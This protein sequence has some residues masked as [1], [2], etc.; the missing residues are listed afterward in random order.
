MSDYLDDFIAFLTIEQ[1]ASAHT[2]EAYRRDI[3][4]FTDWLS[5]DTEKSLETVSHRDLARYISFLRS[6]EQALSA[7]S[8]ERRLSAISSY[9]KYLA[10]E[11]V[12][13]NSSVSQLARRKKDQR[14]PKYLSIVQ[15]Q[16]LLE[17][18]DPEQAANQA[19]ALRD[20]AMIELLYSSGLR[21]GELCSLRIDQVNSDEHFIRVMGKGSKE[22]IVPLGS[23]AQA[24]LE[25][26]LLK[27]RNELKPR[28]G[29]AA[30]TD[31]VFLTTKGKAIH[32]QAVY[33]VVRD[34]GRRAGIEGLHPH[35]L[36]HTFATHLLDG[37]ADLRALQEMLGHSDLSTTQIYTHLSKEHLREEY[38]SAHPRAQR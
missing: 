21:V 6:G 31:K 15:M 7:S 16:S 28:R 33:L 5:T 36:R 37:G 17:V 27:G 11:G 13:T 20:R 26:Y 4:S 22:R 19:L 1:G 32:R 2:L 12:F 29:L 23:Q 34:A 18:L 30:V 14:L 3:T 9:Y 24:C 8:V 38:I 35:T 25:K 10:R